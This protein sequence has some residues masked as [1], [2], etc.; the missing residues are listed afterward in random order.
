[1]TVRLAIVTDIHHGR[2]GFS[3]KS[4]QAL[5]LLADFAVFANDAKPDFVLDLGDRIADED[6]N[7]DLALEREVADVFRTIQAPTKHIC[8]NHDVGFLSVAQNAELLGQPLNSEAINI[9]DWTLLIWRADARMYP[10]LGFALPEHDLIWLAG[11]VTRATRPLAIFT[12]VPLSGHDISAN[13]WFKNNPNSATYPNAERIR[14]ILER[15]KVPVV[16]FSGHVH[17][18]TLNRID[19]IAYATLQ[20]LTESFTT[21]PEPAKAWTLLELN[22]DIACQTFGLDAFAWR[23]PAAQ[24]LQRWLPPVPSFQNNPE[25]QARASVS[26]Q[27]NS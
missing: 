24:T 9:G 1:M 15:A 20:S 5:D 13:Y 27:S 23:L 7:T 17:W 6:A 19:G 4:S 12:H 10:N 18:N 21:H 26:D 22:D 8:G 25:I 2:D 3:K 14:H 16:C 11:Q